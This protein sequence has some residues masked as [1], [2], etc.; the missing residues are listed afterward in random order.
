MS[1]IP[2]IVMI[3]VLIYRGC[4]TTAKKSKGILTNQN[5]QPIECAFEGNSGEPGSLGSAPE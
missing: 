1:I 5:N 3:C 4:N 2:N